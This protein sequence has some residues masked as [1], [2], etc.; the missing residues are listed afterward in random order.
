MAGQ[1]QLVAAATAEPE[2]ADELVAL[3]QA[4]REGNNVRDARAALADHA[5]RVGLAT[6]VRSG[7]A[8]HLEVPELM[9]S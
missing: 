4:L 3:V 5:E 9:G 1:W 8:E 6:H 7:L 2:N